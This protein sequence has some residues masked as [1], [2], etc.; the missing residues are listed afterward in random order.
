M[1]GSTFVAKNAWQTEQRDRILKPFFYDRYCPGQYRFLDNNNPAERY[2]DTLMQSAD[3][4][5]IIEE[6]I[7]HW[8]IDKFT[9]LPKEKAYDRFALETMTCTVPGYER[10]GWMHTSVA[11]Y[12]IY[13][14]SVPKS[15]IGLDVYIMNM[16][17]LKQWFWELGEDAW[18]YSITEEDNR[19]L[20]RIVPIADVVANVSTTRHLIGPGW[21]DSHFCEVCCVEA[22]WGFNVSVRN[23]KP[24]NWFCYEHKPEEQQR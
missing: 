19:T 16:Q 18:P 11:D 13:A 9:R 22:G 4:Q 6:K 14:F 15:E 1:S 2:A 8:P 10:R 7:V 20:C 23:G 24:G 3:G 21:P 5:K 12:L 17:P